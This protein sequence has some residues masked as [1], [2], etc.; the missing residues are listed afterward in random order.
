MVCHLQLFN[1]W[2][3]KELELIDNSNIGEEHVVKKGLQLNDRGSAKLAVNL[4]KKNKFSC[5]NGRGHDS[6]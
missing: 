4:I 2:T 3:I 6:Y 5:K 1:T